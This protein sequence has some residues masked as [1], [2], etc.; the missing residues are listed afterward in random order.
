[1][2]EPPLPHRGMVVD[3]G[4]VEN[5]PRHTSGTN[6]A[7][8]EHGAL[9]GRENGLLALAGMAVDSADTW[10]TGSKAGHEATVDQD[11]MEP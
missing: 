3:T 8:P 10:D 2:A 11:G 9:V 4:S 1:M 7:R 6:G 5:P